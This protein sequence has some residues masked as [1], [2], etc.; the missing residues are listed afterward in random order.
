MSQD[1]LAGIHES[2]LDAL[3]TE[4]NKVDWVKVLNLVT[5]AMIAQNDQVRAARRNF[6]YRDGVGND[7]GIN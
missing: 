1:I 5:N 3:K 2:I 4:P 6:P 7:A